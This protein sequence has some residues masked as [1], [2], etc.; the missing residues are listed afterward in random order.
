MPR[1]TMNRLGRAMTALGFEGMR[2]KGQ[3][4]YVVVAYKPEEIRA[5]SSLLAL[6]ARP[7]SEAYAVSMSELFDT[8]DTLF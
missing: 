4:G 1:L 7:E 8:N 2:S 3:R 5:N 6:D